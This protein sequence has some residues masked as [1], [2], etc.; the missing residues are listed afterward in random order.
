[1]VGIQWIHCYADY[2]K[3]IPRYV[4]HGYF[5]HTPTRF[6]DETQILLTDI[7]PTVALNQDI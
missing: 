5:S 1:M 7:P 2:Q 6:Q 3:H 4:T